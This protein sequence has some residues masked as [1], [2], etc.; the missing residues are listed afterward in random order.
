MRV[1]VGFATCE[2]LLVEVPIHIYMFVRT[3]SFHPRF[4][5][6]CECDAINWKSIKMRRETVSEREQE[7]K[8]VNVC[9][10]SPFNLWR[11]IISSSNWIAEQTAFC[12]GREKKDQL[13]WTRMNH[14]SYTKILIASS[15]FSN[16][17]CSSA[18]RCGSYDFQQCIIYKLETLWKILFIAFPSFHLRS[19]AHSLSTWPKLIE[20]FK[21]IAVWFRFFFLLSSSTQE[22]SNRF[23]FNSTSPL[24]LL[25]VENHSTHSNF[26]STT[27]KPRWSCELNVVERSEEIMTR[28]QNQLE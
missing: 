15:A 16:S 7:K 13:Y 3:K 21:I 6:Y 14:S 2:N 20:T 25:R 26:S 27:P 5:W 28:H 22:F 10:R 17:R 19:Q 23:Q 8:R 24:S 1:G 9:L 11:T 18:R 12:G 4:D